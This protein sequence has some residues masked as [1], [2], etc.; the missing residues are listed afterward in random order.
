MILQNFIVKNMIEKFISLLL[1]IKFKRR[2]VESKIFFKSEF[3][4]NKK[5]LILIASA[6]IQGCPNYYFNN[7]NV[8]TF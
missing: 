3:Q 7:I 4:K 2:Y 8:L 6:R 5:K 1:L